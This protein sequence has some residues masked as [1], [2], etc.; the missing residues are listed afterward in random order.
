MRNLSNVHIF[1]C[2]A[3]AYRA[4]P[5]FELALKLALLEV[6]VRAEKAKW[7]NAALLPDA[8]SYFRLVAGFANNHFADKVPASSI[9]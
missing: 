6:S 5:L 4:P 9:I 7:R 2:I 8:T 3:Y 1:E